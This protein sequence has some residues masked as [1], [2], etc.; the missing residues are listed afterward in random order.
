M[1]VFGDNVI[2]A[3][4]LIAMLPLIELK[5]AIPFAVSSTFWGSHALSIW[6]AFAWAL[7]GS[8]AIVPIWAIIFLPIYNWLK[9][10]KFFGKIVNFFAGDAQKKSSQANQQ[11]QQLSKTKSVIKKMLITCL[12]VAFPVPLTGVWTGVCLAEFMGLNWWQTC[13]S[14]IVGN[15]ICGIIVASICMVFPNSTNI[16]L[17]IFLALVICLFTYKLIVHIIKHKKQNATIKN[18]DQQ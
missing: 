4:I 13:L 3:T 18:T 15:V 9:D 14:T 11:T 6:Q 16:I 5:G 17:Y 8:C 1:T 12:F 10:K 7:L 2:L